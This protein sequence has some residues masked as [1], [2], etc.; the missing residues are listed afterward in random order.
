M[1]REETSKIFETHRR[2]WEMIQTQLTQHQSQPQPGPSRGGLIWQD[3][4]WPMFKSPKGPDE[5]TASAIRSYMQSPFHPQD[6]SQRDRIKELIRK[7]HPDR[8]NNLL[9]LINVNDLEMINEGAGSVVRA[10][11]DLLRTSE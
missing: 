11:N 3:F 1:P 10:L 5:L 2:Q 6:K 8:F 9:P 4:P 7:W